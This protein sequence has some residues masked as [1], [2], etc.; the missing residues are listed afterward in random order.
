MMS[1]EPKVEKSKPID[2]KDEWLV[3][4]QSE[5]DNAISRYAGMKPY[6]QENTRGMSAALEAREME[7]PYLVWT[8]SRLLL[9]SDYHGARKLCTGKM[10]VIFE[11]IHIV[12]NEKKSVEWTETRD[13]M[14]GK[15]NV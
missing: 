8:G 14:F 15:R 4:T 12:E 11:P 13:I 10:A 6:S 9:T 5:L 3:I 1:K 2:Y 7:R